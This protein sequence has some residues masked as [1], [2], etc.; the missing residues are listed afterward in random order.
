MSD[1]KWELFGYIIEKRYDKACQSDFWKVTRTEQRG[2]FEVL[3]EWCFDEV[4]ALDL[5]R[6]DM[7]PVGASGVVETYHDYS[8][9]YSQYNNHGVYVIPK[10]KGGYRIPHEPY[11]SKKNDDKD[12]YGFGNGTKVVHVVDTEAKVERKLKDRIEI[13]LAVYRKLFYYVKA[14]DSE[15]SGLGAV[16]AKPDGKGNKI[17]TLKDVFLFKQKSTG[18]STV[19]HKPSMA[20]FQLEYIKKGGDTSDLKCWWH[21]HCDMGTFW[22]GTDDECC[23][24]FA[25]DNYM[26]SVV[27]NHKNEILGRIDMYKPKRLHDRNAKVIC[28]TGEDDELKKECEEEVKKKNIRS[29]WGGY[30][31]YGNIYCGGD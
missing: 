21:S 5:V 17:Y 3:N 29:A 11:V 18:G 4:D 6:K 7:S 9:I 28:E 31:N 19:I 23:N 26:I 12:Y 14:T 27:C 25:G 16:D 2:K 20:K 10:G 1:T 24:S 15:I 22:S 30:T 8:G 13:P